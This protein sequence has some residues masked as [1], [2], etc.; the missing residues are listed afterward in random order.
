MKIKWNLKYVAD[1]TVNSS[2]VSRHKIE[3]NLIVFCTHFK[4]HLV[5]TTFVNTKWTEMH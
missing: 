5:P 2:V 4:R 1:D 3:N